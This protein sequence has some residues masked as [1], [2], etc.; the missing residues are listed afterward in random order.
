MNKKPIDGWPDAW[1]DGKPAEY[2]DEFNVIENLTE[3]IEDNTFHIGQVYEDE[4]AQVLV[5]AK[6]KSREFNVGKGSYF[7][8]I[9]CANCH[10]EKCIH[11][12]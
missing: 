12:G 6:C 11:D 8:A 1:I 7:T 9:R 5:C 4:A 10:W 2:H 3:K